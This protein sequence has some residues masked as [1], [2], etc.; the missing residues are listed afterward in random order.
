[1]DFLI[2]LL[3]NAVWA[4]LGFGVSYILS[5]RKVKRLQRMVK[6]FELERS[7]QEVVLILSCRED[8]EVSVHQQLSA[9]GIQPQ[10]FFKVHHDGSFGEQEADWM[11]YVRLVRDQVRDIRSFGST[12]VHFFTNVPVAMATFAGALLDNGPQVFVY[13]YFNGV[14]RR[15]GIL[16]HET[17]HIV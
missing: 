17:V 13:H 9:L 3:Q 6:S 1:M 16:S 7:R 11:A 12:R 10:E 5:V 4:L 2:G 8:I 15:V 14:Y